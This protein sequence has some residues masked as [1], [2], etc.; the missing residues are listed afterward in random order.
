VYDLFVF[1][2][3]QF[4]A[5]FTF[6]LCVSHHHYFDNTQRK[7]TSL[8]IGD[9]EMLIGGRVL[10]VKYKKSSSNKQAI[11]VKQKNLKKQ[12]LQV[13]EGRKPLRPGRHLCNCDGNE[14]NVL[15]NCTNVCLIVHLSV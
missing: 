4:Y 8:N 5:W 13:A 12:L 7:M 10:K 9:D 6:F 14:H 1:D 11:T 2:K 15:T 3:E